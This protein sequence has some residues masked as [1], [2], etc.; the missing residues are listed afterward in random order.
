MVTNLTG[1]E[2]LSPL[3]VLLSPLSTSH[4]LHQLALEHRSQ[5]SKLISTYGFYLT[6]GP[7]V[8]IQILFT[9]PTFYFIF[10]LSSTPFLL[11]FY[12][13]FCSI[14]LISLI[15]NFTAF[16]AHAASWHLARLGLNIFILL[17]SGQHPFSVLLRVYKS[18]F[19]HVV[20]SN[21]NALQ[22]VRIFT[23]VYPRQLQLRLI[24]CFP[25]Q[26]IKFMPTKC[27]SAVL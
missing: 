26:F 2:H 1:L 7:H 11:R 20:P 15:L 12:L 22:W 27:I 9:L 23:K 16:S 10:I 18:L 25:H 3:L 8:W 6:I 19:H 21:V 5:I 24:L 17:Q 4:P 14:F 13:I